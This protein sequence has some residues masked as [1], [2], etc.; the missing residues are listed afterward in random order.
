MDANVQKKDAK[1]LV[2]VMLEAHLWSGRQRLK[3]EQ[4][5]RD[6]PMLSGLPQV[7][8]ANLGTV[9]I[10]DPAEI[11]IFNKLKNKALRILEQNGLPLFGAYGIPVAKFNLVYEK[12]K[13]IEEEFMATA[14][15]FIQRYDAAI[16]EW[17][18]KNL[19]WANL[20]DN[21]PKATQVAGRLSFNFH[22]YSIEQPEEVEGTKAN[23]HY[24]E[25]MGGLKG[26][27]LRE[28]AKE[29]NDMVTRYLFGKEKGGVNDVRTTISRRTLQPLFRT[30]EKLHAF[31]F[32]DADVQPLAT[33]VDTVL[34][35]M[36]I[37]GKIVGQDLQNIW[38]LSL[39]LKDQQTLTDAAQQMA[40]SGSAA[41]VMKRFDLL[42]GSILP[43]RVSNAL[44]AAPPRARDTREVGGMLPEA[45]IDEFAAHDDENVAA[46]L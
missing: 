18:G 7:E 6:N 38:L 40:A 15:V 34:S 39:L 37:E 44:A 1:N 26:E 45:V 16:E 46:L 29:A 42:L 5:I 36:P 2:C 27:L 21:I 24:A 33:L 43:A 19:E 3:R 22:C 28:V 4:L 10:C 23:A 31:A 30:A 14:A 17:K 8:L 25:T 11:K 20:F 12:L 9:K 32:L 35:W 13:A 41:G